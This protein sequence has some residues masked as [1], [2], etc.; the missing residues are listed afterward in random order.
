MTNRERL[1]IMARVE[2]SKHDPYSDFIKYNPEKDELYF[3]QFS[4]RFFTSTKPAIMAAEFAVN[5]ALNYNGE[6][7]LDD[8]Y[9][10]CGLMPLDKHYI[11]KKHHNTWV[12][13]DHIYV[14]HEDGF[15]VYHVIIMIPEPMLV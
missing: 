9:R 7:D 1:Q 15:E 11:W 14:D 5:R 3:D 13:F 8:F 12:D 6:C 2:M 4:N 10:I